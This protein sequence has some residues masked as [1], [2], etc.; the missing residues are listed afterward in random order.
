MHYNVQTKQIIFDKKPSNIPNRWDGIKY[1]KTLQNYAAEQIIKDCYCK[2]EEP[3]RETEAPLSNWEKRKIAAYENNHNADLPD[4]LQY[5][6]MGIAERINDHLDPIRMEYKDEHI[7]TTKIGN[8]E[9]EWESRF[10]NKQK[11]EHVNMM[12]DRHFREMCVQINNR[13]YALKLKTKPDIDKVSYQRF[14]WLAEQLDIEPD[15][16]MQIAETF[17]EMELDWPAVQR[18]FRKSDET[19]W[20]GNKVKIRKPDAE[21]INK[22]N[23]KTQEQYQ[24]YELIE[25]E[26]PF[27][28]SMEIARDLEIM[29]EWHE[30]VDEPDRRW[31]ETDDSNFAQ[32]ISEDW[33]YMTDEVIQAMKDEDNYVLPLDAETNMADD[34]LDRLYKANPFGTFP[35]YYGNEALSHEFIQMIKEADYEQL[36]VIMARFFPQ[37][38][39]YTGRVYPPEYYYLS[40]SQ[41]SQAWIYINERRAQLMA[42]PKREELSENC[43]K[44]L[45]WISRFGKSR[46]SSSIIY[47]F[48]AGET[49]N[50][51]GFEIEF[52]KP[53][54]N[55]VSYVWNQYKALPN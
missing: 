16:A 32:P 8:I 55:E 7:H 27:S 39:D 31:A 40:S 14:E 37:K 21:P 18:T 3:E 29:N 24:A 10:S 19:C 44:C 46:I 30:C 9:I 36:K 17:K 12:N 35:L 38:N 43:R 13:N 28:T 45:E 33:I 47:A 53:P 25:K 5:Y 42:E 49:Y 20:K 6:E 11:P 4:N 54:V 41:K 2:A 34:H 1:L 26:I 15:L 50:W 23:F 52:E 51:Q 48:S 22:M